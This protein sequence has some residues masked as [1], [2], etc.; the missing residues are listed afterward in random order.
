MCQSPSP[1]SPPQSS[2]Y[3]K[4]DDPLHAVA[5][6]GDCGLWGVLVPGIFSSGELIE[7]AY[8]CPAEGFDQGLQ[9]A[10]RPVGGLAII[11][12]VLVS[13]TPVFLSLKYTIGLRVSD[14]A[15]EAGLDESEHGAQA[16]ELGVVS[17]E[18]DVK[19]I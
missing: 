3:F 15:Q 17:N 7:S 14:H 11:A 2:K 6:H 9:F 13:V 4:I 12:W 8:R 10:T 18:L 5:V 19:Q 16:Y 1:P